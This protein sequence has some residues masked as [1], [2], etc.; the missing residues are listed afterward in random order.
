MKKLLIIGAVWPEPNSTAAGK[1]MLQIISIFK[2]LNYEITFCSTA[3][4]SEHSFDLN[5][6]NISSENILLNDSSFDDFVKK[7]Q[8][9]VVL[10]DRFMTEEQFGWRVAENVPNATKILDTEDLHFLRKQREI[11]FKS[12]EE[13]TSQK[14]ISDT[15]IREI[16]SILRCDLSL[17]I[18]DFEQNLLIEKYKINPEILYY[19]PM[20]SEKFKG[21]I[22]G[23]QER[24]NFMHIG[25]FL[26]E[27]NWQTVLI[28]KKLWKSIKQKLPDSEL[29]I[30]GSYVTE[31]A[32]Q[33]HNEKEGF[34]IKGRANSVEEVF[35][36]YK[37]LLA[38]IPFG[39]GIKGKLL[40]SMEFGLPNITTEIGAEGIQFDENWN[41]FIT[42]SDEEFIEK[43]INLYSVSS[44]W[45][46]SQKIG[47][48]ILDKKFKR[49]LFEQGFIERIQSL[50]ENL[51]S[52][53]NENY[54]GKILQQNALQST[55]FMS[56]WIEEKNKKLK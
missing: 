23:F 20:F 26:H 45:E 9:D 51:E 53:R 10:F 25:N 44:I 6:L 54:L 42:K 13:N 35:L 4:K 34:I 12:E 56:K 38:R 36:N 3:S 43:S 17:I 31:K 33:L 2:D 16:S 52:H 41:G 46:N 29:H 30:Y 49:N 48:E 7:F 1:R 14:E 27:P 47:F 55:K 18:S 50:S 15:F 40:E 37:V 8:P 32:K 22:P 24:K 19:L 5:F 39:A 21:E 11:D 28:L